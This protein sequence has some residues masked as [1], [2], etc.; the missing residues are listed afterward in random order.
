M[1]LLHSYQGDE[2]NSTQKKGEKQK[3][4]ASAESTVQG[5]VR[6]KEAKET[7]QNRWLA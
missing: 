3:N 1:I 6:K 2:G 4:L 7:P 5:G